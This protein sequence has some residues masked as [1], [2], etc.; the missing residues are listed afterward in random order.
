MSSKLGSHLPI[1]EKDLAV[2]RESV[3]TLI[4][5]VDWTPRVNLSEVLGGKKEFQNGT[6]VWRP[7]A[8]TSAKPIEL[9]LLAIGRKIGGDQILL[10]EDVNTVLLTIRQSLCLG[11]H[12]GQQY[13]KAAGGLELLAT[14]AGNRLSSEQRTE[15]TQK[16]NTAAAVT[17]FAA[18]AYIAWKLGSYKEEQVSA[19]QVPFQGVPEVDITNPISAVKC[20]LFY[21][22]YYLDP[23]SARIVQTDLAMVKMALL[24]SDAVLKDVKTRESSLRYTEPFTQVSYQFEKTDFVVDGFEELAHTVAASVE[25]KKV[26]FSEIVGNQAPKHAARRLASRLA[27]YDPQKKSNPFNELGGLQSVVMGFGIAGTGKTMIISATATEMERLCEMVG[28]PFL[29]WPLPDNIIST[30]QG[31]SAERMMDWMRRFADI[32]KIIYGPIDDAENNFEDRTRPNISAGVREVIGVYLRGTEGASAIRRGNSLIAYYTNLAEQIDKP[33]LSRVQARWPID[34]AVTEH[35]FL[36]Q[37][38]LWWKKLSVIDPKFIGM[39]DPKDYE[40]MADQALL[41][42]LSD[43]A[44]PVRELVDD[45]LREV[46]DRVSKVHKTTDHAFYA[47]LYFGVKQVFP[48]FSSRDARNIQQAVQAR[49]IDFDLPDV[50]LEDPEQF[51]R[52]DYDRKVEMLKDLMR[53]QMRKISFAEIRHEETFRYLNA[54]STILN[55]DRERKIAQLLEETDIREEALRRKTQNGQK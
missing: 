48:G 45:R 30:Y 23:E 9:S 49:V 39:K 17:V 18:A 31:G 40:Y 12:L 11:L 5:K 2:Q 1:T 29:F 42:S 52:E 53:E 3:G 50:W 54:M 22:A 21:L 55:A 24:F 25:F 28:L 35:D 32:D 38:Y 36:D 6:K 41:R 7:S 8:T 14:N 4:T 10:S 51:Y 20:F 15:F 13:F 37:D 44:Q 47:A 33:V 19:T 26:E 46:Y 34:G 16:Q 27:C 43:C